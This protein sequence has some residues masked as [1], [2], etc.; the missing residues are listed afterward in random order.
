MKSINFNF[1]LR[2]AIPVLGLAAS[3]PAV[4]AQESAPEAIFT[5]DTDPPVLNVAFHA[6]ASQSFDRPSNGPISSYS[7]NW[8][9]GTTTSSGVYV[10]HTYTVAGRYTITLTVKDSDNPPNT[11]SATKTVVISGTTPPPDGGNHA[12]SAVLT[13]TPT[14]GEVG[15]QFE[16][17][18][19][20]STDADSDPLVYRF[21]FGDGED[22]GFI[23]DSVVTHSYA[24][25][26]T[27]TVQ[28][29]VRDDSNAS[30]TFATTIQVVGPPTD[31]QDP[32]ALIAVGP[33]TASAPATLSFDG[34]IS[35]DPDGDPIFYHWAF[36]RSGQ[37][38]AEQTG[39]VVNQVFSE[40]GSYSVV[41]RV[42]DSHGG[43]GVSDAQAITITQ[44]EPVEPPPPAPAP[45]PEPPPPSYLQRPSSVCGIGLLTPVLACLM[46]LLGGRQMTQRRR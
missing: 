3:A 32:V 33:R 11:D 24:N 41:L 30:S 4:L 12:P 14:S 39:D 26:G 37:P 27:Y 18:A 23:A 28:V 40:A 46:G 31:N 44:G 20:G 36:T 25:S 7:W 9:D 6:D 45:E 13:S 15:D 21:N 42:I 29:T 22:T 2:Y 19:S 34:R 8:G 43:T 10:A 35:Y 5:I 1:V 17:D 16:F 38:Y